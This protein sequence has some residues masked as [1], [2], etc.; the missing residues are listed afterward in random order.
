MMPLK[1]VLDVKDSRI[2]FENDFE[3]I[4][5]ILTYTPIAHYTNISHF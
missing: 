3:V 5:K 4:C 1:S 2:Y